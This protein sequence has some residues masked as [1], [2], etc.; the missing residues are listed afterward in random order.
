MATVM[1][2]AGLRGLPATRPS[3]V[4]SVAMLRSTPLMPMKLSSTFGSNVLRQSAAPATKSVARKQ[5]VVAASA[6]VSPPADKPFVWGANMKNLGISVGIAVLIWFVPPPVGVSLKAWHL[7]SVFVG[8]IVGIITTPLPLGAVAVLGLGAA[9]MTKVLTFAEAFSAFSSEIP[10]LIAIAYFLAGGFIKSGLGNRIA[11]SIV[12]AF[13]AT[14]LGLTYSLVFAEALLSPAIPSVAARAGGIFFPLAKALCLA[15]GSDPE[16]GTEKKIGAY[17]MST[18]FQTSTVSSAMFITAMAAN[19]LAVNLALS[20]GVSISWGTWALAALVPGVICLIGVPLIL[21]VL[22]PPEAKDT[23]DAPAAAQ[24][25]LAKLGPLSLNEKITAG[26][27]AVTVA[28]WIFGGAIGVNAVSAGIV[29]LT[30]L[31]VSNVITWKECLANGPAWDTLTWFAALIAMAA[32]LNKF[33]FIPWF[34]DSVVGMVGSLGLAWQPAF[35]IVVLLYFYSHYFF[36]SGAAHIG[37]MYT[38]F[39]AVSIACGTPAIGT[40]LKNG[41]ILSIFY[42]TVWLGI[43]GAWWKVIG[44][45]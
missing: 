26:A 6:A 24:K 42:L 28:L 8:T 41:F 31:L 2:S 22:M 4:K 25:E 34:S 40:W 37:A 44:L 12:S 27:F 13:G 10:W 9:M 3:H 36:A 23:P 11:Y 14:T 29:G 19:P 16:K 43:G 17:L 21:Y 32:Y 1:R 20:A 33:G 45:Y 35:G 5:V 39:L 30:I 7:L 15:C 18:C 38:A